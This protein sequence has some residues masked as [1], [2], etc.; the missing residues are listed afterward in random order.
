ME[1]VVGQVFSDWSDTFSTEF[2]VSHRDYS[3]IRVTPTNAP[4][5]QVYFEDGD[6]TNQ[7]TAGDFIRLGTE[8]SSMGN[9]LITETWDYF[10]SA[11]WTVGDHDIKFGANTRQRDLQ[12]LPA[13][14]LGQLQLPRPGQLQ[15]RRL[16]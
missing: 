4:T 14:L 8:R 5:I 15:E 10:G 3:A 13:G 2:K 11:T 16:L 9:S 12:L 6:L 7:P 1:R